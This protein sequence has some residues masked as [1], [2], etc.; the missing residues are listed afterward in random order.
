VLPLFLLERLLLALFFGRRCPRR[1]CY[2]LC[3]C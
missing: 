3:H 2:W 1:C